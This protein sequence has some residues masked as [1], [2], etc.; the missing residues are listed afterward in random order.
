M[1]H[2]LMVTQCFAWPHER[3][4]A[5]EL[6]GGAHDSLSHGCPP[7]IAFPHA[8]FL[9]AELREVPIATLFTRPSSVCRHESFLLS[10]S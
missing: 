7:S 9:D 6:D 4:L 1:P 2:P 3:F 5:A 8:S 10:Q